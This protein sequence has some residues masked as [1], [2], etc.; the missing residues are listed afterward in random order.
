M[1]EASEA[2]QTAASAVKDEYEFIDIAPKDGPLY[3]AYHRARKA[4]RALKQRLQNQLQAY[5]RQAYFEDKS[6]AVIEAQLQD[7]V[8]R[9][10]L[11]I[12]EE[13]HHHIPERAY[14]AS[15]AKSVEDIR[16]QPLSQRATAVHALA[17]L[18]TLVEAR[19][20]KSRSA[21]P[22]TGGTK[23]NCKESEVVSFPIE[24]HKLQCLFCIGDERLSFK[25]Q[26]RLFCREQKLWNHTKN[27]L[28][29]IQHLSEVHCPHPYCRRRPV[30]LQGIQHLKNH[31][32]A[33]HGIR[34]QKA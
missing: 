31:A 4:H 10:T 17:Q 23:A 28:D 9:P 34:L 22:G 16:K 21:S 1:V 18:C 3:Q 25:D 19:P 14:L 2:F 29:P 24:C 7:V 27:H 32:Y 12:E 20:T 6:L 33:V 15:L 30:A 13:H 5:H 11:E 8:Q 26:T